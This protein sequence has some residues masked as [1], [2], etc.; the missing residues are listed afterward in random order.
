L[1]A[2]LA[3]RS[4]SGRVILRIEDIDSARLRPGAN[5]AIVRDLQWLGI[6]W[7]EG[8][9]LDGPNA[10]YFQSQR[11]KQYDAAL[12][13]LKAQEL[14]YP[15]TCSRADIARAA[16]APHAEDEGPS[17][18]GTCAGRTAA[19]AANITNK[20]YCWRFRAT[21][22][23]IEWHDLIQGDSSGN[24][25]AEGGDFIV[26]RST[27]EPSYQLAVV[28]DDAA[29]GINQ[30]IRGD[31]LIRSTPRQILLYRAFGWPEPKFGHV[32]IQRSS[33]PRSRSHSEFA[34]SDRE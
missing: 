5:E 24:V 2:W 33:T 30:V 26:G 12:E 21:S 17:Y 15:C 9:D 18:P 1:I 20:A 23:R 31:D 7:D 16:S 3:A 4:A 10:P 6:D 34:E 29:M 11:L 32:A 27:G 14:V 25:A 22:E 8:A 19:Y 28:C 13:R